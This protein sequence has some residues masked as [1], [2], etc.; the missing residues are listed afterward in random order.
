[1]LSITWSPPRD[2]NGIIRGY[3]LKQRRIMTSQIGSETLDEKIV[4]N[5]TEHSYSG[6]NSNLGAKRLFSSAA[7]KTFCHP[8]I[9]FQLIIKFKS[10]VAEYNESHFYFEQ[11]MTYLHTCNTNIKSSPSTKQEKHRVHGRQRYDP[12]KR[13]RW[14]CQSLRFMTSN[15]GRFK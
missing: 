8:K 1:M 10:F 9:Q 7:P 2:A 14:A 12:E 4:A 5:T 6:K 13:R 15:P 3:N 11:I